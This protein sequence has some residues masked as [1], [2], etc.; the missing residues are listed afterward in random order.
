MI[1][2]L[3]FLFVSER[4]R[5]LSG[6]LDLFFFLRGVMTKCPLEL[7]A[8]EIYD[9]YCPNGL[10]VHAHLQVKNE[11]PD[12]RRIREFI[13]LSLLAFTTTTDTPNEPLRVSNTT[14]RAVANNALKALSVNY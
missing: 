8:Y 12:P 3:D 11:T 4:V 10:P 5:A 6:Y 14:G 7:N 13:S 1:K 2:N 9:Y